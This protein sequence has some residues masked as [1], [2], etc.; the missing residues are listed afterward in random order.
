MKKTDGLKAPRTLPAVARKFWLQ[1][2]K[3][4]ELERHHETL[5]TSAATL[6]GR[7]YQARE[8]LDRDGLTVTNRFHELKEHPM[9]AVER[10]SLLGFKTVLLGHLGRT[11]EAAACL[12]DYLAE[13]KIEAADDYRR[14][15]VPNSALV[16]IN[17]EGLRKAGWKV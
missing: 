12:K 13:R 10:A 3:D 1:V 2:A 11:E 8:I 4:F 9:V 5:L 16:E 17:L 6:L 7:A 15:F 14:I